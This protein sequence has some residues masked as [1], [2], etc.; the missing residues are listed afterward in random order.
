MGRLTSLEIC[1]GAG[2]PAL[3]LEAAGFFHEALVEID[4]WA[5][6]TLR[7][8]RPSWN[9][10]GPCRNQRPPFDGGT[11]DLRVFDATH[12]AGRIDLLAGGVPCPPFS[13]AGRQLGGDD[14]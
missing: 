1:A 4:P 5:A 14:E 6:E 10:V 7:L 2:G 12:W 8:N 3:G 11:G 13:K 9:V